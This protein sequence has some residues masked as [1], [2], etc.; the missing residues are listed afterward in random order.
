MS[1]KQPNTKNGKKA[2]T[3]LAVTYRPNAQPEKRDEK[4]HFLGGNLEFYE[5]ENG[6]VLPKS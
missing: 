2:S 3:F 5:L 1:W 6:F 4:F